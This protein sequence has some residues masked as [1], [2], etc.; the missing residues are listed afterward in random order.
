MLCCP[1]GGLEWMSCALEGLQRT[2]LGT[3]PDLSRTL[4]FRLRSFKFVLSMVGSQR[5]FLRGDL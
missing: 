1:V 3:G 2:R 4:N 5:R